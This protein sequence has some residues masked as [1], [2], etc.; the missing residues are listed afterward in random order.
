MVPQKFRNENLG[1]LL[2]CLG[3]W[4]KQ[5]RSCQTEAEFRSL[6]KPYFLEE[7]QGSVESW[8]EQW[9]TVRDELSAKVVA[10]LDRGKVARR[11]KRVL[12]VLGI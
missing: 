9:P 7:A 6:L 8:S 11:D 4:L 10:I 3:E 12:L 5:N 2:E 1:Q